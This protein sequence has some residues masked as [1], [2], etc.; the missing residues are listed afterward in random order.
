[1]ADSKKITELLVAWRDG[2]E[3]SLERLVPLVEHELRRMASAY[4]RRESP[5]HTLQTDAL[6]NEAYLRLV[7]QRRVTWK[8]RAHFFA[9]AATIMR[10]VLLDHARQNLRTKRGGG[11]A[12]H[13]EL[14]SVTIAED[15]PSDDVIALDEALVRLS[16]FDPFKS[17]VVELRHFGGLSVEETAEVLGVSSITVIRNWNLAKAWLR[18]ELS[19]GGTRADGEPQG[20][21]S[22]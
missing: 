10:R 5:G 2:D 7:D 9:L 18:R 3:N 14:S 17:R 15:P 21:E 20:L 22:A 6:V 1:M 4:M 16:E 13:V 11:E 19:T 12:V 8:N